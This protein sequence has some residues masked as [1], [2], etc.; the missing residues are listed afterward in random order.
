MPV[1]A[2]MIVGTPRSGTTL[3]QRLAGELPG[4]VVTPE[5]HFFPLVEREL[6]GLAAFPKSSSGV[7]AL[8]E[9]YC[10]HPLTKGLELTPRG[11]LARLPRGERSP[12]HVFS[13]VVAELAGDAEAVGEKT[14]HHLHWW[15]P[16]TVADP[17]LR[18][19][20]VTRDPRAVTASMFEVPFGMKRPVLVASQWLEDVRII[21]RAQA[22]LGDRL[23]R[24]SF[25]AMVTDPVATQQ[26]LAS[27]LGVNS[28][29]RP[30]PAA[31][32]QSTRLF[33][34]W[35]QGWK[36][37]ALE[38]VTSS[39]VEAWRTALEPDQVREVEAVVGPVLKELGYSPGSE[40]KASLTVRDR[41]RLLWHRT[42]RRRR[43]RHIDRLRIGTPP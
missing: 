31:P 28:P 43:Q 36:G 25:E 8:L 16:L 29:G 35:E 11:V 15:R 18:L 32:L 22:E 21:D 37:R 26:R 17:H 40:A 42:V 5:T 7:G 20:S 1:P 3:L 27:F 13:A 9:A 41:G 10:T 24:I 34:Q 30:G 2:F 19:V 4:V 6:G 33:P 23:L 38:P 39:R 14:P 12:Y